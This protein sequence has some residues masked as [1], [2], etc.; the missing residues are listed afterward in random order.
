MQN[1]EHDTSNENSTQEYSTRNETPAVS[2]NN[3][4]SPLVRSPSRPSLLSRLF[5]CLP[6][7]AK[8]ELVESAQGD[9]FQQDFSYPTTPPSYHI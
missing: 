6:C 5:S 7:C 8:N 1:T 3:E 2:S 9:K 4:A